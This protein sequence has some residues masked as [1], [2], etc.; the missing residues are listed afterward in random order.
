MTSLLPIGSTALERAI[1]GIDGD[2]LDA[3]DARVI[4]DAWDPWRCPPALLGYLAYAS[5]IDLWDEAW[6]ETK[7]RLVCANAIE[8]HRL[9]GTLA[10]VRAHLALVD[11]TVTR[12]IRPPARGFLRA[13]MTDEQRAAWLESLPQLRLYPFVH[14]AT[15][16][17]RSFYRSPTRRSVPATFDS[18]S[19]TFGTDLPTFDT[20]ETVEIVRPH[21]IPSRAFGP[22]GVLR[23][24]RGAELLGIKATL[25]DRGTERNIGYAADDDGNVR[26]MIGRTSRRGWYGRGF[27]GAGFATSSVAGTGIVTLR[28]GDEVGQFAVAAGLD[29]VNVRPTRVAQ[30][31]IAPPARAFFGRP[32]AKSFL[33]TSWA[34][35]LVYDRV[36]LHAPDRLGERRRTRSFHGRGRFGIQPFTAELRVAVPLHRPRQR[37][38][39]WH[40][41]GFRAVGSLKAL[42]RALDAIRAS[43]ALRDTVLVDTTTTRG[44]RFGDGLGFGSFAFGE[45]RKVA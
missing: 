11:C 19:W 42:A 15:A 3:V 39:D 23:K 24:S 37:S 44:V 22:R 33:R 1:D 38:G 32:R 7:K 16:I 30:P 9:K 2:R 14:R 17:R 25:A 13:A 27:T 29:P 28:L 31:R 34:P 40:G 5:S 10:G 12:A 41:S 4:V 18:G 6:P 36:S 45:L 20:E 8:L 43:K 35:N 26:L 21:P